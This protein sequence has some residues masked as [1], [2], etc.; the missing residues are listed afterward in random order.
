M[1]RLASEAVDSNSPYSYLMLVEYH[2]ETCA[3]AVDEDGEIAGFVTGFR[4][5]GEPET[6][7][8]WQIAVAPTH[9]GSGIGAQLLRAVAERPAV[10]RLR[11]V[12]AT[13]NPDNRAS[14][15]LFRAFAAARGTACVED[16]L[17]GAD[18]FPVDHDAEIRFR[19]GPL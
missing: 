17:F 1:W 10:P 5:P 15:A 4:L 19:I 14:A 18:D 13:V 12:E 7:F 8:I 9:R 11:F 2:A 6:L 16:D 3:V